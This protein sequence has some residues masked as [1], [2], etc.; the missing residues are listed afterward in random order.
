MPSTKYFTVDP[1]DNTYTVVCYRRSLTP[2]QTDARR[3]R[4]LRNYSQIQEKLADPVEAYYYEKEQNEIAAAKRAEKLPK[5]SG[6]TLRTLIHEIQMRSTSD[7]MPVVIK[8]NNANGTAKTVERRT[9]KNTRGKQTSRI[10]KQ[11]EA[12]ADAGLLNRVMFDP[13]FIHS[14]KVYRKNKGLTQASLAQLIHVKPNEIRAFEHNELIFDA[15]L[16]ALLTALLNA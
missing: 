7:R 12:N 4:R 3:L 16:K 8:K 11:L 5:N 14:V 10:Q 6:K 13:D 9:V 2:A 1:E 15:S